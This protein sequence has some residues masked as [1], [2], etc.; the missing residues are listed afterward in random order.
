MFF[1]YFF[2]LD[3]HVQNYFHLGILPDKVKIQRNLV[4]T[5]RNFLCAINIQFLLWVALQLSGLSTNFFPE[6]YSSAANNILNTRQGLST[7]ATIR[8]KKYHFAVQIRYV[9][10]QLFRKILSDPFYQNFKLQWN[11]I[12]KLK[13]CYTNNTTCNEPTTRF[14]N[15]SIYDRLYF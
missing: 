5:V 13:K 8:V 14:L 9:T 7:G 10:R 1:L 2:P 4:Q 6:S 11:Y 12:S 15:T 3:K